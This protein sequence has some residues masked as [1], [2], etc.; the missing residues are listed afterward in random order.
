[1]VD[2]KSRDRIGK[3]CLEGRCDLPVFKD[4]HIPR[5]RPCIARK[6]LPVA[7]D[8]VLDQLPNAAWTFGCRQPLPQIVSPDMVRSDAVE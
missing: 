3:K 1:M 7:S 5:K 6:M 8:N 2:Y 4:G